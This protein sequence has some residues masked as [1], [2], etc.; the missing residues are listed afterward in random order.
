[1]YFVAIENY[2][3]VLRNVHPIV[4]KVFCRTVRRPE[5]KWCV[6]ALH[7][8]KYTGVR[9]QTQYRRVSEYLLDDG[10]DV[11]KPLLIICTRPTVSADHTV[12][13]SMGPS[14]NL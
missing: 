6:Y 2:Y 9:N 5:P 4:Y 7:L 3:R 12:E 11:W 8:R 13:F 1:M 10:S 14:L